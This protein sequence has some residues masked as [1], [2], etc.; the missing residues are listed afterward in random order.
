MSIHHYRR[1]FALRILHLLALFTL[2]SSARA[3]DSL[4]IKEHYTKSEFYITM[5]D[6]VRLFTSVYAPKDTTHQYPIILNRTPYTVAPYGLSST[7]NR[8]VPSMNEVREGYIFVYQDVRGR[9][10]SEGTFVDLR[11]YNPSKKS[12]KDIDETTDTYDTVDWLVNHFPHNNGPR[13]NHRNFLSRF[14]HHDGYDRRGSGSEGNFSSG[15]H[16]RS[17]RR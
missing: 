2:L 5:R 10:M 13:R 14:L 8:M 4:Y 11:P 7:R 9:F 16:C 15:A 3:Q 1:G 17:V 12:K 6:G